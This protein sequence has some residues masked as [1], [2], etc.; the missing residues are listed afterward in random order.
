LHVSRHDSSYK[1]K[2]IYQAPASSEAMTRN[3]YH[4]KQTL[5]RQDQ[6][7]ERQV[8]PRNGYTHIHYRHRPY[9]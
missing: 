1:V 8:L 7:D 3:A 2:H 4:P 6:Y 5:Y 9:I